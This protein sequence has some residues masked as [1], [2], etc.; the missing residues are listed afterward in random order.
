MY[1]K[2]G[3]QTA[4][5]ECVQGKG[6]LSTRHRRRSAVEGVRTVCELVH[7]TPCRWV[8]AHFL[9]AL[10]VRCERKEKRNAFHVSIVVVSS[11]VGSR[12]PTPIVK[13]ESPELW[14]NRCTVERKKNGFGYDPVYDCEA[15]L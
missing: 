2:D 13:P 4:T 12:H 5:G 1:A 11:V 3:H 6:H 10:E 8:S 15:S 7:A 9:W 14:W